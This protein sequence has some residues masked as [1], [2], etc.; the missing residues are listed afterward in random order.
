M[1]LDNA[2]IFLFGNKCEMLGILFWLSPYLLYIKDDI[3]ILDEFPLSAS[4][5]SP[6]K[7]R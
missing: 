2:V 6:V 3:Y 4:V 5:S 1:Q 7:L